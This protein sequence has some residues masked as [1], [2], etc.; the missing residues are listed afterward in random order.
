MYAA[1]DWLTAAGV[2]SVRLNVPCYARPLFW[3]VRQKGERQQRVFE[4]YNK[5]YNKLKGQKIKIKT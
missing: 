2:K 5:S 4:H 1:D 3:L